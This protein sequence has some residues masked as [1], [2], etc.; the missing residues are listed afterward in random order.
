MIE[1]SS[2]AVPKT[3]TS[4]LR[5]DKGFQL[6]DIRRRSIGDQ[7]E[8]HLVRLPRRPVITL[9]RPST[10]ETRLVLSVRPDEKINKVLVAGINQGRHFLSADHVQ[11]SADQ[12]KPLLGVV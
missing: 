3:A 10:A 2:S 9:M 7:A 5:M 1:E 6:D 4:G 12:R 8:P 11:A